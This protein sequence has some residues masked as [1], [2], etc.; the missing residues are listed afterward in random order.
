MSE[1][2][3]KGSERLSRHRLSF[4]GVFYFVST[5]KATQ[6][7]PIDRLDFFQIIS[8][9]IAHMKQE[10]LVHCLALVLMP[11]HLHMIIRLGAKAN[12]SQAIKLFKGRTAHQFN[13]LRQNSGSVWYKGFH[14]K[15]IR[16]AKDLSGYLH[17]LRLNPVTAK[18]APSPEAW[19]YL[20]INDEIYEFL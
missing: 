11:D 1:R 10:R 6:A 4:P 9:E 7:L 18:L 3:F 17:Y 14:D 8:A 16:S 19:P 2:E 5:A 15:M 13:Q 20:L 12:L